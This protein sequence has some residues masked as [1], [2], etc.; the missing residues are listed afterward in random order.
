MI[1]IAVLA[2]QYA[3]TL[4]LSDMTRADVRVTQDCQAS[5]AVLP[6]GTPRCTGPSPPVA[7]KVPEQVLVAGDLSTILTAR[8]R[9]NDRRW[10]YALTSS[11]T[12]TA[13]DFE[14]GFYPEFFES[15][16]ASVGWHNRF[17]N[18]FVS[19]V[20]SYG[21]LNSA[22]L[23]ALP[24]T[25]TSAAS[26]TSP[27]TPP[28]QATTGQAT[29]TAQPG[30][31]QAVPAAGSIDF[32]SSSTNAN[33]STSVSRRVTLGLSG[34][35]TTGGG[36]TAYARSVLPLQYGP[37]AA[38]TMSY[39]FWPNDSLSTLARAQ[40]SFTSGPCSIVAPAT[41]MGVMGLVTEEPSGQCEVE[42]PI[43]QLEERLRHQ[44]SPTATL[45]LGAGAAAYE[46]PEY[47]ATVMRKV[48]AIVPVAS[49]GL[50]EILDVEGTSAL[51]LYAQLAP[52]ADVRTGLPSD[53][54]Q[55]DASLIDQFTPTAIATLKA[56]LLQSVPFVADPYPL[57]AVS[58]A[59]EVK[60]HVVRQ[61]LDV[62]IG[63]QE[64][65]QSQT[66]YGTL[67]SFIGYVNATV[68]A[69]TFQF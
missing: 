63:Q 62:A 69:P 8:L 65:W 27:G 40:D 41:G 18:V 51:A 30:T 53:R 60:F 46:T 17:T 38:A 64:L 43:A 35:Y 68:R 5:T 50:S 37:V 67:F 59:A 36:L 49:A 54:V 23:F 44:L 4:D 6:P 25:P 55:I 11:T 20:G 29:A 10:D 48:V 58:G 13:P 66:G 52:F 33:I 24:A 56:S 19:E 31:L 61:W 12:A 57:T 22:F 34:G 47:F 14:I 32:G 2:A 45:T 9:V 15:V 3:G 28:Q 7:T 42:A 21:Q 26:S 39:A 1:V 16:S